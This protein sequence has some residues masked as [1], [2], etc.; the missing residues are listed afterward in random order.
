MY[1]GKSNFI[2]KHLFVTGP[3]QDEIIHL[4]FWLGIKFLAMIFLFSSQRERILL[5]SGEIDAVSDFEFFHCHH[6]QRVSS[7]L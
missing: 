5:S 2:S 7:K 4:F 3:L 6:F 1:R